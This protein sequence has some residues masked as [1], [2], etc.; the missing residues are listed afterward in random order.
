MSR[1]DLKGSTEQLQQA[2]DERDM[3]E[4]SQ[5]SKL[6]TLLA[7]RPAQIDQWVED[8]VKDLEGAQKAIKLLARAVVVLGR[9]TLRE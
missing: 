2:Q 5:D 1:I 9:K 4:V 8:N 6:Q 7:A 3:K